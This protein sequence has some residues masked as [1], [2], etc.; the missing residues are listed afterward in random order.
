QTLQLFTTNGIE[1]HDALLGR[2][3]QPESPALCAHSDADAQW[4]A[5]KDTVAV[6]L[7]NRLTGAVWHDAVRHGRDIQALA[8]SPDNRRLVTAATDRTAQVWD[9]RP[10]RFEPVVLRQCDGAVRAQFS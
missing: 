6:T 7:S 10:S 2:P 8:F 9:L 1:K 5:T 4:R 3:P